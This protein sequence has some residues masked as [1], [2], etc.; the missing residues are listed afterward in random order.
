MMPSK[1]NIPKS[2]I[3]RRRSV[4]QGFLRKSRIEGFLATHPVDLFYLSGESG[5]RFLY[6]PAQGDVLHLKEPELCEESK[7]T[8]RSSR[9]EED[10]LKKIS[11]MIRDIFGGLP[12]I[13]GL[14]L[15]VLPVQKYMIVRRYFPGSM[16]LD[17]TNSV[18][19]ARMIKSEWELARMDR[20]AERTGKTF[21]YARE[22]LKPGI[23]EIAFSGF[24]EA[25]AG[26]QGLSG[27]VKVRDYKTEGYP[28]HI[29]AGK[30]GGTVG[31]LDAPATGEGTS[32][33]FPCGAGYK[34]IEEGEPVM[35][36]FAVQMD[37]YHMDET[38]MF[39]IGTMPQKAEDA[40]KAA[41]EIHDRV[42]DK[43]KP[44][45]SAGELFEYSLETAA[46]LGYEETYLGP[47]HNKVRF[48]GHGIG[49]EL[50]E[51]PLISEG[52]DDILEPGMTFALEPKMVFEGEFAAGIESIVAVTDSGH[53]LISAMPVEVFRS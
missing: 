43:V 27:R 38:R 40:C 41:I 48:V 37:G 52:R 51:P 20:V 53:R 14:A 49:L 1:P 15:D 32:P 2:E 8:R 9:S 22:A 19:S 28:W 3:Q 30:S 16:L 45:L 39:V 11:G 13:L 50:I 36:D 6:L 47:P 33:A 17:G 10:G 7:E 31:L 21:A 5:V 23:T 12:R 34:R 26:E 24:M 29:L 25:G 18:L 35:V 46:R 44:G 42:I 4:V